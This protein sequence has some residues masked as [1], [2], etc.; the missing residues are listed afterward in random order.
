LIAIE[1]IGENSWWVYG[2]SGNAYRDRLDIRLIGEK[3]GGYD[4]SG[5]LVIGGGGAVMV[6]GDFDGRKE[7]GK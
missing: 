6:T 5:N 7:L 1:S 3:H 4:A 2:W